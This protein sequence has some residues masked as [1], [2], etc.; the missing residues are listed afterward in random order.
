MNKYYYSIFIIIYFIFKDFC[1]GFDLSKLDSMEFGLVPWVVL[2]IQ[3]LKKWR[4]V[5]VS[6]Y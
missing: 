2:L 1:D 3:A 6:F 5:I 4:T